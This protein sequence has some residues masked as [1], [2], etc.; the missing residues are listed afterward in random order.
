MGLAD[1][2]GELKME[3]AIPFLI[4][5]IKM[6]RLAPGQTRVLDD[7]FM[8]APEVVEDQLP[9]VGALV[10]I[11][12]PASRALMREWPR[13]PIDSSIEAVF[14]ISRIADPVARTFLITIKARCGI[15]TRYADRGLAA[16]NAGKNY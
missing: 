11:G 10:K 12:Q 2:F 1:V 9:A 15:A 4:T 3:E 5:N 16:I 6:R 14:A 7:I 13:L 8:K